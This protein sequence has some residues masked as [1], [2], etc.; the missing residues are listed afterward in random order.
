MLTS[1]DAQTVFIS[2]VYRALPINC[3]FS[4]EQDKSMH[5]P[6]VPRCLSFQA[7]LGMKAFQVP[8]NLPSSVPWAILHLRHAYLLLSFFY[9]W[10]RALKEN[11]APD[12]G[13]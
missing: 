13:M 11:D 4:M 9:S 2:E 1:A 10:S 3:N 8:R 12:H 7:A 6:Y 5:H